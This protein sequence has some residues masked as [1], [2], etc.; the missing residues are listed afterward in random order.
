MD[1]DGAFLNPIRK[2]I[3]MVTMGIDFGGSGSSTAFVLTGF[4]KGFRETVV[5]KELRIKSELDPEQ[6]NDAFITFAKSCIAEYP[7]L[8]TVYA[9]SAEQILIR[10][11]R[12]AAR[13]EN[14]PLAIK[15]AKKGE[16]IDRIRFGT[17]MMAQH[18]YFMVSDCV[19]TIQAFTDAVWDEKHEDV[20]LDD[21]STNIDSIDATEYS[22]EPFMKTMIDLKMRG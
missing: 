11:L 4:T 18:R 22:Q 9:D 20:R 15:N 13:L 2:N 12:N 7:L 6:L 21:G 19:E 1:G 14:L 17:A 3:M 16:I 5:L 8:K 10:G